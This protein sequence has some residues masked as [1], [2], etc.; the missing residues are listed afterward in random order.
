MK[1][2]RILPSLA[3][4]SDE[5][6]AAAGD[7][8]PLKQVVDSLC[9]RMTNQRGVRGV[10]MAVQQANRPL[11]ELLKE[12]GVSPSSAYKLKLFSTVFFHTN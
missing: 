5:E 1:D 11:F 4:Q 9:L 12:L 8:Q 10:M 2:K 3:S 6:P 7:G